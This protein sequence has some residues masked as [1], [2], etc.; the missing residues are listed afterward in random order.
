MAT[1]KLFCLSYAGG[2]AT[3]FLKWRSWLSDMIELVPVELAGRG[4]RF[5][6]PLYTNMEEAVE[7]LYRRLKPQLENSDYA[8]YG[9]SMGTCIIYELCRKIRKQ[10]V[11]EP[12]WLF[13]SGRC[14]PHVAKNEWLHRLPDPRFLEAI[15][16]LG[17]IP[18]EFLQCQE[19]RQLF[20]PILKADHQLVEE[21]QFWEGGFRLHCNLSI[22][23]GLEDHYTAEAITAWTE[24]TEKECFYYPFSGGHFFINEHCAHLVEIINRTLEQTWKSLF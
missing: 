10:K 21:Y 23:Y 18:Q 14:A 1:L 19:L 5:G 24:L 2:S 13:L 17:G 12:L 3:V 6:Q 7:D 11:R 20:T 22:F 9:H 4:T 8:F 16:K 15:F